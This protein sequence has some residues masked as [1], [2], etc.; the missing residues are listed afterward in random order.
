MN[1][2]DSYAEATKNRKQFK[3]YYELEWL[4]DLAED[5]GG[6]LSGTGSRSACE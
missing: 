5:E 6:L 4:H 3:L 2:T 1:Q